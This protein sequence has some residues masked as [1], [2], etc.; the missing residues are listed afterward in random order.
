M[1]A[2]GLLVQSTS[3]GKEGDSEWF[4]SFVFSFVSAAQSLVWGSVQG[5]FWPGLHKQ[6][7]ITL[8]KHKSLYTVTFIPDV[9]LKLLS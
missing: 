7:K 5:D 8:E 1:G 9:L 6:K 3:G 4:F 2:S